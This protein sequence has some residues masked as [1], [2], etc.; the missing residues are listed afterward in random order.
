MPNVR[1]DRHRIR[2]CVGMSGYVVRSG[3]DYLRVQVSLDISVITRPADVT[4]LYEKKSFRM[5]NQR[6]RK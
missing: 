1:I 2:Y 4:M 5:R 3:T 6:N